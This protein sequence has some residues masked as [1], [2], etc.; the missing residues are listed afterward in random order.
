MISLSKS[1]LKSNSN[2]KPQNTLHHFCDAKW[3]QKQGCGTFLAQ[4]L[5]KTLLGRREWKCVCVESYS[6]NIYQKKKAS[7]SQLLGLNQNVST[8]YCLPSTLDLKDL[9]RN[10]DQSNYLCGYLLRVVSNTAL[11][12]I[13]LSEANAR[14]IRGHFISTGHQRWIAGKSE[15]KKKKKNMYLSLV[16]VKGL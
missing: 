12:E 7:Q 11:R 14:I 9:A 4:C 8:S 16:F 2:L 10:L 15:W 1:H 13:E 5:C 6:N 3:S